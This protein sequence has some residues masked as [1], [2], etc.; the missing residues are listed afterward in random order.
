MYLCMNTCVH[1][2]EGVDA[3]MCEQKQ[4]EGMGVL[5]LFSA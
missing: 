2:C 4:E 5:S 3:C 1:V